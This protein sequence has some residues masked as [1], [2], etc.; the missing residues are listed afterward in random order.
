MSRQG[1]RGSASRCNHASSTL[2]VLR[3]LQGRARRRGGSGGSGRGGGQ[4]PVC[5]SSLSN[6]RVNWLARSRRDSLCRRTDPKYCLT[7]RGVRSALPSA[8]NFDIIS[9]S[10]RR[11]SS[12][13]R[14]KKRWLGWG[15][16]HRDAS[17]RSHTAHSAPFEHARPLHTHRYHTATHA[18]TCTHTKRACAPHAYSEHKAGTGGDTPA[19]HARRRCR[20]GAPPKR[21]PW[22]ARSLHRG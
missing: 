10:C 9:I 5:C 22:T 17:A 11:L 16:T 18:P 3:G 6:R 14:P 7:A 2:A 19:T 1:R 21:P 4:C 13:C 20:C 12:S 8:S 15:A